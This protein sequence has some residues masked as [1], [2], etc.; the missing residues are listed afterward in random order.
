MAPPHPRLERNPRNVSLK[1]SVSFIKKKKGTPNEEEIAATIKMDVKHRKFFEKIMRTDCFRGMIRDLNGAVSLFFSRIQRAVNMTERGRSMVTKKI[2]CGGHRAASH[3]PRK[4]VSK[5][6][7]L[8][9][10]QAMA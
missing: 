7:K 3:P 1:P 9:V 5:A 10:P 2:F 6:P 8:R 4:P